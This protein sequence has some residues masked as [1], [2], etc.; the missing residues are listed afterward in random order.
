MIKDVLRDF[1]LF[2]G[3]DKMVGRIDNFKPPAL[4]R[5]VENFRGAGMDAPMPIDMGMEPMEASW[6]TSGIDRGM[7]G[8]FG[9]MNGIRVP[10]SVRAALVDPV[11]GLSKPI[12]H[13]MVGDIT[14]VEPSDYKPGERATLQT[15]IA[16]IYYKLTHTIPGVPVVEIDVVNGI[17]IINGVDQLVALRL[18]VGR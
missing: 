8:G 12:V 10:V 5:M 16:L 9:L 14:V 11:T 7:Y 13:T 18:L 2:N 17:R 1:V 15:T 3:A 6:T 4:K